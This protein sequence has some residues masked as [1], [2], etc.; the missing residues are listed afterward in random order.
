MFSRA[1]FEPGHLTASAFITRRNDQEMFL[2]FHKKLQLW[3]QPGGHIESGDASIFAAATRELHE[4]VGAFDALSDGSLFDIDIHEIPAHKNEP[5]HFHYDLRFLFREQ[6][7]APKAT[8]EVADGR[9][10]SCADLAQNA[11][12]ASVKRVAQMLSGRSS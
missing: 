4:E 3:L 2:I 5:A 7:D 6:N 9:Y 12:D 1:H 8:E 10:F 11:D